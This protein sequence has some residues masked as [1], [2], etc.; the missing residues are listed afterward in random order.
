MVLYHRKLGKK[1]QYVR[2]FKPCT[3]KDFK[4]RNVTLDKTFEDRIKYRICPDM[5]NLENGWQ[6]MVKN[7]YTNATERFS[8]KIYIIHC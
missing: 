5:D 3:V 6:W 1:Q 4:D 8:F 7:S 2:G